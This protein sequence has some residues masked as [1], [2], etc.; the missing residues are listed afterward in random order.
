MNAGRLVTLTCTGVKAREDDK[1]EVTAPL[2][3]PYKRLP[4]FFCDL[5]VSFCFCCCACMRNLHNK[6]VIKICSPTVTKC[7]LIGILCPVVVDP[8]WQSERGVLLGP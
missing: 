4:N 1:P 5:A 6:P 8:V 3:E 2:A 7:Q